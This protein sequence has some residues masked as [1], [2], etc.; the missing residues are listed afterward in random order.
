MVVIPQSVLNE[1]YNKLVHV[2]NFNRG[3]C[4]NYVNTVDGEH[5]LITPK[6]RR[7]VKT[8]NNLLYTERNKP[9]AY[10]T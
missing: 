4:F 8:K 7:V 2:E 3:A 9:V 6:T 1:G 5:T 10:D